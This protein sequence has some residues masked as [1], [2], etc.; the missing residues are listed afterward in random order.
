MKNCELMLLSSCLVG[1]GGVLL[2]HHFVEAIPKT[3]VKLFVPSNLAA[4]YDEQGNT[5]PVNRQKSEVETAARQAG[6]PTTVILPGNFA[7]FALNTSTRSYVAAGH[8]QIFASTPTSQL[9][10]RDIALC[11]LKPTGNEIAEALARKFNAAPITKTESKEH[12]V[13]ALNEAI[14]NG[15]PFALALYC[16]KIWATGEKARM[17]G[18]DFWDVEDYSKATLS[19]LIVEHNLESYRSMPEEVRAYFTDLF[20]QC[21]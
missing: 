7:E 13:Q 15:S 12:I 10:G 3:Q 6:I 18:E 20:H 11:E 14:E 4:R 2:Q 21:E 17:M 8:A 5:I 9:Q 1:H 19:G 16:R